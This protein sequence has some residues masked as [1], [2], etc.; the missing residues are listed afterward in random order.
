MHQISS[1]TANH[2]V[3]RLRWLYRSIW[4]TRLV[5]TVYMSSKLGI[6]SQPSG[7]LACLRPLLDLRTC[8][9][10]CQALPLRQM[11]FLDQGELLPRSLW[12]NNQ[13]VARRRLYSLIAYSLG[14]KVE[15]FVQLAQVRLSPFT[16]GQHYNGSSSAS[17]CRL[18]STRSCRATHAEPKLIK[19]KTLSSLRDLRHFRQAFKH[20]PCRSISFTGRHASPSTTRQ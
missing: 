6:P 3:R 17:V 10:P 11:E 4:A 8:T 19:A 15:V 12:P 14:S 16:P 18:N 13:P 2:V 20:Q 7:G 5:L 9:S 1:A